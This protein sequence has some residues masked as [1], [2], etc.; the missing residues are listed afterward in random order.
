ML[1]ALLK[2]RW[3]DH[4]LF[5]HKKSFKSS[6]AAAASLWLAPLYG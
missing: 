5:A 6:E 3:E 4:L 2:V 1:Y